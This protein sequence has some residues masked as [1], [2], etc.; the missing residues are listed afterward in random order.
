MGIINTV[1]NK[2]RNQ[3]NNVKGLYEGTEREVIQV[4]LWLLK[5]LYG[6]DRS[7]P[8]TVPQADLGTEIT[9]PELR[10]PLWLLKELLRKDRNV[11]LTVRQVAALLRVHPTTVQRWSRLGIIRKHSHSSRGN[12]R[13]LIS[14][15]VN[16]LVNSPN[17]QRLSLRWH[18]EDLNKRRVS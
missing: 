4:P 11:P 17:L 3:L 18:G 6:K 2:R 12:Q 1:N 13:F 7:L 5:E 14:D 8:L 16:A 9:R 15:V 10:I